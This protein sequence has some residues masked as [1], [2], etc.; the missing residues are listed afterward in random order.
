MQYV[1]GITLRTS[2]LWQS[3]I[4]DRYS[5]TAALQALRVALK[6][7]SPFKWNDLKVFCL[8]EVQ[9][10]QDYWL[11]I[12]LTHLCPVRRG[13]PVALVVSWGTSSDILISGTSNASSPSSR[14]SNSRCF[15][16]D[17][18]NSTQISNSW[19]HSCS[20]TVDSQQRHV[21]GD[22]KHLLLQLPKDLLL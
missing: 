2:V 13:T 11:T 4:P 10:Y 9:W 15:S 7:R 8:L 16:S 14:H 12:G 19:L 20:S 1:N 6:I 17:S 18:Y 3:A 5:G 22:P 21:S